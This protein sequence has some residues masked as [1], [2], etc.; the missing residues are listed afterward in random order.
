M[1]CLEIAAKKNLP[2][3]EVLF[4]VK[5]LGWQARL[6]RSKTKP[7]NATAAEVRQIVSKIH[8]NTEDK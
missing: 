5:Q 3:K 2:Y 6:K 1:T 8:K 4:A 7:F